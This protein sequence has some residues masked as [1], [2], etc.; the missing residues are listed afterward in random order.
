MNEMDGIEARMRRYFGH[1]V[2]VG[3]FLRFLSKYDRVAL[4]FSVR[5]NVV[6]LDDDLAKRFLLGFPKKRGDGFQ[7]SPFVGIPHDERAWFAKTVWKKAVVRKEDRRIYLISEYI[8]GD[9]ETYPDIP[10]FALA[11]TT[12][13][14]EKASLMTKRGSLSGRS[15]WFDE[16]GKI[17]VNMRDTL[18]E[19]PVYSLPQG[20]PVF[21]RDDKMETKS[22]SEMM[23]EKIEREGRSEYPV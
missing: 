21:S 4:G 18:F 9:G 12:D 23:R 11:I 16:K 13:T 17:G 10:Q 20:E 1:L 6:T 5:D 22:F 2:G 3:G 7:P 8:L 14:E 19:I 15:F